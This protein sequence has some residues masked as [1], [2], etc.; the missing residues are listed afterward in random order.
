[1]TGEL[2]I[3]GLGLHSATGEEC[4]YDNNAGTSVEAQA[5]KRACACFRLGRYLYYFD[6]VWADLDERKRPKTALKLFGWATPGGWRQGLRPQLVAGA[7]SDGTASASVGSSRSQNRHP[8]KSDIAD[9]LC[10]I[11]AFEKPLGKAPYR[12]LLNAVAHVCRPSQIPDVGLLRKLLAHTQGAERGLRRLEAAVGITGPEALA[13]I[14]ANSYSYCSLLIQYIESTSENSI[15]FDIGNS[16]CILGL[17]IGRAQPQKGLASTRFSSAGRRR[18]NCHGRGRGFESR[19]S[20]PFKINELAVD[21]HV[22][23]SC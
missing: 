20:L 14:S 6:G 19:S 11:E 3:F 10:Q 22:R 12:G 2:T 18:V 16:L 7:H 4:T 5:F 13:R 1:M 9:L 17:A 15:I 23:P 8:V 21:D